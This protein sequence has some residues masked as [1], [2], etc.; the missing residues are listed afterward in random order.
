MLLLHHN[1]LNAVFLG[2]LIDTFQN[3]GWKMVSPD[4]ANPDVAYQVEP[5]ALPMDGDVFPRTAKVLGIPVKPF[6][7]DVKAEKL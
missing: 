2:D 1:P 7:R 3:R 4:V 5:K 6:F